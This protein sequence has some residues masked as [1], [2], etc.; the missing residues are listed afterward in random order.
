MVYMKK[1]YD[2]SWDGKANS[3]SLRLGKDE[4]P[5]GTYYYLVRFADG[6]MKPISGFLVL[7]H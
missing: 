3:G 1:D 2:N 4:L 5:E 6:L 7:R